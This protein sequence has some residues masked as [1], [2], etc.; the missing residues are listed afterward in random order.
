MNNF[1]N[2]DFTKTTPGRVLGIIRPHVKSSSPSPSM[3]DYRFFVD[4]I[5]VMPEGFEDAEKFGFTGFMSRLGYGYNS[6]ESEMDALTHLKKNFENFFVSFTPCMKNNRYFV[7]DD[8]QKEGRLSS[9]EEDAAYYPIPVFGNPETP[10]FG[11]DLNKFCRHMLEGKPLPGLSKKYW[12]NDIPCRLLV[13]A[14]QNLEGK[15]GQ[16]IL[17]A[18]LREDEFE[19]DVI[20]E[21]GAYFRPGDGAL[22]YAKLDMK[23]PAIS[24][25]I[26]RLSSGPLWYAPK[27]FLPFLRAKLRPVPQDL[28][29][30][31][32]L[33]VERNPFAPIIVEEEKEK[34]SSAIEEIAEA[35]DNKESEEINVAPQWKDY[36]PEQDASIFMPPIHPPKS[37]DPKDLEKSFLDRLVNRAK[38]MGMQYEKEDLLHFHTS[39]KSSRLTILAGASGTGKSALVRLYGKALGLSD[40]HVRILPVKPSWMDDADIL[41]YVDQKNMVYRSADTGLSELLIEAATTP[42]KL[43]LVCF[44]E[45]NLARAEHYFAQ[46]IS[47]LENEENPTLRLYNPALAPRLYNSNVYPPEIS[48]G[49]NVLFVGTVNVD[50]STYRF[51]DKI[52]DRANVLTLRQ[53]KFKEWIHLKK[54]EVASEHEISATLF[55]LFCSQNAETPQ[56]TEREAE[57]FDGLNDAFLSGGISCTIG[58]RTAKGIASY[59]TNLPDEISRGQGLDAQVVQRIFTK[60]RGSSSQ[61]GALLSENDRGELEGSL[62]R[63]LSKFKDLSSFDASE[64]V[65]AKKARELT[66]YDYTI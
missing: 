13:A 26:L 39:L 6:F 45:M 48:V 17:F 23:D 50:E 1:F 53:G 64:K 25:E 60:L 35:L 58:Y 55:K 3:K 62:L 28:D 41:G 51:S 21:G 38:D 4:P 47:V 43:Y 15:V 66:L 33:G 18:P 49:N 61:L 34:A 32:D 22:G 16:W 27:D 29:I 31:K 52:L 19:G 30:F 5:S 65:L 37:L 40:S 7:L 8:L 2:G 12:N 20:A 54:K 56:L 59:L 14:T 10:V 63:V 9:L 36:A 57:F 11:G 42:E 24:A 44:D 46:F